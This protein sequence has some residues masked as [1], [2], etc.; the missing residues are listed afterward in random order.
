M[1]TPFTFLLVLLANHF[2][3][4][5]WVTTTALK[6][7]FPPRLKNQQLSQMLTIAAGGPIF[8]WRDKMA[9]RTEMNF[10]PMRKNQ[11]V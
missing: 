1:K 8:F 9:P 4:C 5:Q 6:I 11:Q 3:L 7:L 2:A 10:F